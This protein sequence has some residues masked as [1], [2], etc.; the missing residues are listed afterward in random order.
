MK[1]AK[2]RRDEAW[3]KAEK[4]TGLEKAKLLLAGLKEVTESLIPVHYKS[5]VKEVIQL[6]PKDETGVG[7]TIGF[8]IDMFDL[9]AKYDPESRKDN[10]G[11]VRAAVDKFLADHPKATARQKQVVYM[12]LTY[13]YHPPKDDAV[14][15]KSEV[16]VALPGVV[17]VATK[18]L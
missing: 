18:S 3:K 13:Y 11:E 17:M 14:V 4:A 8:K 16:L 15:A 7:A 2:T 5:V 10:S 1:P 12:G 9:F 6:D